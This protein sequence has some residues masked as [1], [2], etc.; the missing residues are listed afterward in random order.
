MRRR[1]G[2]LERV[3]L[4]APN[5]FTEYTR[6]Y[7]HCFAAPLADAEAIVRRIARKHC[8]GMAG[9]RPTGA[10]I[11]AALSRTIRRTQT[12]RTAGRSSLIAVNPGCCFNLDADHADLN[13]AA[14]ILA[15]GTGASARGLR[16]AK[17]IGR[18][19]RDA[20][21]P[22][23]QGHEASPRTSRHAFTT[24]ECAVLVTCC[25]VRI[26]DLAHHVRVRSQQRPAIVRFLNQFAIMPETEPR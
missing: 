13:A 10:G 14:N 15:L 22:K 11:L 6:L 19:Q 12:A 16:T 23:V 18:W 8:A 20:V 2:H 4:H 3:T 9:P 25:G 26:E 21:N 5:A 17:S 1:H 24:R 7:S